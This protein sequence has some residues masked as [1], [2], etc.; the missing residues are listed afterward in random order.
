MFWDLVALL[1]REKLGDD[2]AV[3]QPMVHAR[4]RLEPREIREFD[5]QL[6]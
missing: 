1:D 6:A 5:E 4:A 3:V 2:E